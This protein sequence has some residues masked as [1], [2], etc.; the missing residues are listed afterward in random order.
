LLKLIIVLRQIFDPLSRTFLVSFQ[1][2]DKTNQKPYFVDMDINNKPLEKGVNQKEDLKPLISV[3]QIAPLFTLLNQNNTEVS[4]KNLID[5]DKYVLLVFY[6]KDQTPGCTAQL[7]RIRDDYTKFTK[8]GIVVL[9]V[10]HDGATSHQKFIDKEGYQFDILIDSNKQVIKE[11]G[12][13]KYFFK[14][15]TIQR[16]VVLVGPDGFVKYVCKGQQDNQVI[17]DLISTLQKS[18]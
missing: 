8:N 4:L 7:C 5:Q 1:L 15:I 16:S 9:G 6:P 17:L 13:T 10:N 3:G 2:I 18:K 11:Y 12:A 14:N